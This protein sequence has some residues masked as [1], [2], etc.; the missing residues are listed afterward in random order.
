M[1]SIVNDRDIRLT[2][3]NE[4]KIYKQQQQQQQQ[5]K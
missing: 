1:K 2:N 5:E 3:S 4:K